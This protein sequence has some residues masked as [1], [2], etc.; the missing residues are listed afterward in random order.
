MPMRRRDLAWLGVFTDPFARLRRPVS[1]IKSSPRIILED[2]VLLVPGC[3]LDCLAH[4]TPTLMVLFSD[5]L[6]DYQFSISN[7]VSLFHPRHGLK[8]PGVGRRREIT[9]EFIR[10]FT[11][12][13]VGV[14]MDLRGDGWGW[15]AGSATPANLGLP[16]EPR[17]GFRVFVRLPRPLVVARFGI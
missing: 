3:A 9:R 4:K 1:D 11:G 7:T 2:D 15:R 13:F 6:S 5:V 8:H 17:V 14:G 16:R 12:V 10:G